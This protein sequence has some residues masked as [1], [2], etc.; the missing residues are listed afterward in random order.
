MERVAISEELS[1]ALSES[2]VCL[3]HTMKDISEVIDKN[4]AVN[5]IGQLNF[6]T[7]LISLFY[8]ENL[9]LLEEETTDRDKFFEDCILTLR[10]YRALV[11]EER[12]A[13]NKPC[14]MTM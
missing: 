14:K 5:Q 6:L 12:E 4:E 7:N 13:G 2:V 8:V 11:R 9:R 10:K 1:R 3:M